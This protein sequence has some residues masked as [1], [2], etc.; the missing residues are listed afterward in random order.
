MEVQ[1][2]PRK[3]GNIILAIAL[4]VTA[5]AL[6]YGCR[7]DSGTQKVAQEQAGLKT[8][9]ENIRNQE[10]IHSS[11][12]FDFDLLPVGTSTPFEITSNDITA[13]FIN[14]LADQDILPDSSGFEIQALAKTLYQSKGFSG[15]ILQE[16]SK[17]HN[18]LQIRFNR[19][20]TSISMQFSTIEYPGDLPTMIRLAAFGPE[21]SAPIG[22]T[23]TS[24]SYSEGELSTGILEFNS[25]NPFNM[26]QVNLPNKPLVYFAVDNIVIAE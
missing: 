18:N 4:I 10:T 24:G 2:M 26:V 20:L 14:T 5:I 13:T 8:Q 1:K 22:M 17:A 11:V 19:Q 23:M 9:P 21:K 6:L 16:S 15:N 7:N 12:F 3:A 25:T